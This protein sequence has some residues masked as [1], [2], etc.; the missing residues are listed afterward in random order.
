MNGEHDDFLERVRQE[1]RSLRYEPD[2]AV[3]WDRL[4]ARIEARIQS[5]APSV[6]SILAG[7]FRLSFLPIALVLLVAGWMVTSELQPLSVDPLGAIGESSLLV[8]DLFLDE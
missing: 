8:E 5:P 1:A 6:V 2:D 4:A 3:V 7:W